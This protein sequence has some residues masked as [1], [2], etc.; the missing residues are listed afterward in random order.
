M[1][2]ESDN[3][4]YLGERWREAGALSNFEAA[5]RQGPGLFLAAL[6]VGWA[7][8]A[9]LTA[10][11][12]YLVAPRLAQFSPALPA[13]FGAAAGVIFG[14]LLLEYLGLVATVYVR[15]DF[16]LPAL[17]WSRAL[18]KLVPTALKFAPLLGA[19]RDRLIHS[20][21]EVSNAATRASRARVA[22]PGPVLV[23]LPRCLQRPECAQPVAEDVES[24]KRCGQCAVAA[25]LALRDELG[26]VEMVV[27]TGGSSVP[28]LVRRLRPR[29]VVGVACERE[30]LA[31]IEAVEGCAVLGVAN[32]RPHGPCRGTVIDLDEL[33]AAVE[34]F[35]PP[36]AAG[37]R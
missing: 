28:G 17:R 35:A 22:R 25:A 26:G 18:V 11:L 37:S 3:R 33:R 31:G 24:C 4:E 21:V 23:L 14:Y 7:A 19:S 2:A 34:T 16:L 12:G 15:R 29:A 27:L 20:F 30:I 5:I 8:A 36:G 9:A 13:V 10:A 6:A 1:N 32:Q